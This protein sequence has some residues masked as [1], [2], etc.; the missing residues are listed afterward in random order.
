MCAT[1]YV[2]IG[3]DWAEPMMQFSLHVTCSCIPM[4]TFFLFTIFWYIWIA[5]DFSDCFFLPLSLSISS[6]YVSASMAPKSKPTSSRNP[7]CFEASSSSDPFP[8]FVQFNDEDAQKDFS[9]NFSRWGIHSECRV[10][11]SD[12]SD[13]DLPIVI[14]IRG[15]ESLCDILI[16]CP[17][18]LIQEFYFNMH[19][20]D[21]SV[22]LFHTRIRGTRIVVTQDI[23]SEVLH[24]L[25]V[26][27][28]DYP[29]CERLRTVSKD[30]MI[31]TFCKRLSD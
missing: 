16:T 30:E 5:W 29:S 9:G 21:T 19:G 27:H 18:V 22:P 14:H 25:R 6:V 11:L 4:H 13:T 8:F 31:S 10:I 26:E 12:F 7:L 24:V 23:V 3:L 17:S 15:W 28:P 20:L 2:L 1:D